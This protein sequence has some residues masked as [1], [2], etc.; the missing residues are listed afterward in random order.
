MS[1]YT[2]SWKGYKAEDMEQVAQGMPCATCGDEWKPT[3]VLYCFMC[4]IRRACATELDG[5]KD[6]ERTMEEYDQ[7]MNTFHLE[8]RY[9]DGENMA[10][11]HKMASKI[12]DICKCMECITI[13][14]AGT[15]GICA[16][17]MQ[18]YQIKL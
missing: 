7:A 8:E 4:G 10:R 5:E 18:I 3:Y 12:N 9:T 1:E 15:A 16:R 11:F 14:S 17:C 6:S 2:G 13:E